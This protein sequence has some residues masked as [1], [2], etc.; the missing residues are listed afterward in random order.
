MTQNINKPVSEQTGFMHAIFDNLSN[1]VCVVNAD[2][3][4][5]YFNQ[6]FVETFGKQSEHVIGKRFGV[7]VGC[8]GHENNFADG[9]CN[10]CK[11]RLSMQAAIISE[12]NQEKESMVMEMNKESDEEI[13]LIQFQSNY[14]MHED[15]KYA[16]VILNDLTN[17][18]KETLKFINEFYAAQD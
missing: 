2:I 11:L 13:R 8:K 5:V 9:I 14:L 6:K 4:I 1:V 10:N 3:E 16:V 18:G 7:S 17:M 12:Q 15:K